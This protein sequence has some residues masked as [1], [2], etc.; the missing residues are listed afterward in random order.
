[1]ITKE[2]RKVTQREKG[3]IIELLR[4]LKDKIGGVIIMI[5]YTHINYFI[6]IDIQKSIQYD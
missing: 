6:N 4:R 5:P 1:M 2:R 3:P